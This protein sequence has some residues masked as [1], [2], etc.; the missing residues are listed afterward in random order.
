[1]EPA[2]PARE[3]S[4]T[5]GRAAFLDGLALVLTPDFRHEVE[6]STLRIHRDEPDLELLSDFHPTPGPEDQRVRRVS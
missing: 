5:T 3:R 6:L 1:M 4:G 2:R